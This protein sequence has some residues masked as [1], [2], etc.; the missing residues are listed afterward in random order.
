MNALEERAKEFVYKLYINGNEWWNDS[1]SIQMFGEICYKHAAEEQQ[2]FDIEKSCEWL[3]Q[4]FDRDD[5]GLG[6]YTKKVIK[7]FRKAMEKRDMEQLNR[8]ELIG[9]VG[10][11]LVTDGSNS[12]VAR[13]SVATCYTYGDKDGIPVVETTWHNVAACE[14]DGIPASTLSELRRGEAVYVC[15]RLRAIRYTGASGDK[16]AYEV[17]AHRLTRLGGSDIPPAESDD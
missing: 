16:V 17:L 4:L 7:Q 2:K 13:L 12:R 10:N 14:G 1:N 8:I 3:A 11:V 5:Y 15:G 9:T 6:V